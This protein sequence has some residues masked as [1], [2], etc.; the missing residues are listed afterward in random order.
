MV[1]DFRDLRVWEASMALA[2]A[3]Y[4]LV[5]KF[6][7]EERYGLATQLK[8]AA[9]SVPSCIAEGNAREST[10]DYLRFLSMAKGSLAEIQ[11]QVQL[12]TRLGLVDPALVDP[13][14]AKA[15]SVSLLLQSLRKALRGKLQQ[16]DR[17]PFPI[18]HSRF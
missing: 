4:E 12:A 9:V 17:S 7:A 2:E 10:R 16:G 6:P 14:L 8:R 18:P 3:V 1:T 5:V 15:T 13:V 11:T